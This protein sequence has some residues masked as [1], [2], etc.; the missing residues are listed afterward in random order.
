MAQTKRWAGRSMPTWVWIVGLGAVLLIAALVWGAARGN[1][2]GLP[3]EITVQEAYRHYQAGDYFLLDVRTPQ[4][5]NEAHVPGAVLIPLDELPQRLDEVPRDRPVM[6]I[7]RSGNRS[8]VGRDILKDAGFTQVT[9]I[10]GGIRAWMA[11]GY[12]VTSGP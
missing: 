6:V 2:G 7:C 11:A 9:S 4:E 5:W 3:A 1:G 8:A 12:P 10:A